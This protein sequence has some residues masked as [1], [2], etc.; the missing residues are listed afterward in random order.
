MVLWL[1]TCPAR[2]GLRY[3]TVC[4]CSVHL[5]CIIDFTSQGLQQGS[6]INGESMVAIH[7]PAKQILKSTITA[8]VPC[9]LSTRTHLYTLC[10]Y[11]SMP[12]FMIVRIVTLFGTFKAWLWMLVYNIIG[13]IS[14][15]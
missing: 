2:P 13:K 6:W 7:V 11:C 15:F 4:N 3:A 10:R 12:D 14:K 9:L 5:H 8:C 1:G